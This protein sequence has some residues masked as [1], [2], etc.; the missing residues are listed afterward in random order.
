V[1]PSILI[2]QFQNLAIATMPM[3]VTHNF[4]LAGTYEVPFGK[5]KRYLQH[6]VLSAIAGGWSVNAIFAHISGLPFSVSDSNASLNAPGNTQRADQVKPNVDKAGNG[7]GGQPYFDPLAFAP[8]RTPRFGTAG[9]DRLRGP[10]N[11]N[12][13]LGLFRN[14]AITER[15]RLQI[16]AESINLSN[17]PHF[18]NPGANVS[19]MSLNNDGTVKSLGG[20][21]QI[22]STRA[23]GRLIDQRYFRFG[24]RFMF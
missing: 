20:F 11:N 22:S 21:S 5:D 19:N 24:L 12:L 1:A 15:V 8:V 16:R 2:P 3:D 13:D 9:Y 6:G 17:T 14:F 18:S 4:H 7:V 10:G 23:L